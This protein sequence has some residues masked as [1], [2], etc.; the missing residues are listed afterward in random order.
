MIRSYFFDFENDVRDTPSDSSDLYDLIAQFKVKVNY[1]DK[2]NVTLNIE[3]QKNNLDKKGLT[4]IM[5]NLRGI[6][7]KEEIDMVKRAVSIFMC[8]SSRSDESH[9]A[10]NVGTRDTGHS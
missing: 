6:K 9:E 7:T 5:S 10:G 2:N 8:R 3:P 1:P 4:D